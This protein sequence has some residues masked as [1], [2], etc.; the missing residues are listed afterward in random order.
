LQARYEAVAGADHPAV[1]L[2]AEGKLIYLDFTP[3]PL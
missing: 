1:R 3:L 2:F